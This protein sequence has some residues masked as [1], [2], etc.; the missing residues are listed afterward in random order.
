MNRFLI[1]IICLCLTL[2]LG[3]GILYP[4]YQKARVLWKK[5]EEKRNELKYQ[6]EYFSDLE[7]ASEKL[8]EYPESLSK[9]DSALPLTPDL[10]SFFRFLKKASFENGLTLKE[11][12]PSLSSL[13]EEGPKI[14]ENYLSFSL[15]GS[16]NAFKNFLSVLQKSSRIIGVESI[17]FSLPKE[18]EIF[19]FNLKIKVYSY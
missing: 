3:V 13:S 2:L 8:K 7:K 16:Y 14:K 4:E 12:N 9:I 19:S 10:P 17:N 6:K 5:I 11:V 1:I 15:S 18:E